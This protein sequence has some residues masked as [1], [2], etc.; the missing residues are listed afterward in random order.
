[1]DIFTLKQQRRHLVDMQKR[2]I[3]RIALWVSANRIP[4]WSITVAHPTKRAQRP[5][6]VGALEFAPDAY[7]LNSNTFISHHCDS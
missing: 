2:S 1:M 6:A 4:A 7:P 5:I 3:S